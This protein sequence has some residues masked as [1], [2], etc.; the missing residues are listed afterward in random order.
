MNERTLQV[1]IIVLSVLAVLLG[2]CDRPY[3]KEDA[4]ATPPPEEPPVAESPTPSQPGES[5][6]EKAEPEKESIAVDTYTDPVLVVFREGD[7]IVIEGAM[8]SRRQKERIES[9]LGTAFSGVRIE[10]KLEVD[11]SRMPVG[12]GNRITEMFLIPYF[13]V[14]EDPKVEYRGG[15]IIL[16][17][18]G[19]RR[20]AQSF[21]ELAV[22]AFA[23]EDSTDIENRIVA[24]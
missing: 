13:S 7:S 14:I 23:G 5:P 15:I 17:G 6:V 8:K 21:H 18:R 19:N 24:Y 10:N 4:K 9:Q 22:T 11:Y 12:W 16:E 20:D 1:S 2:G 3:L